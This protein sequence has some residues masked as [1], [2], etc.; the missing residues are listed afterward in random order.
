MRALAWWKLPTCAALA[1]A[2]GCETTTPCDTPPTIRPNDSPFIIC[3]DAS[4]EDGF[5]VP[6][7]LENRGCEDLKIERAEVRFDP[8]G[9]FT[10]PEIAVGS[11][12]IVPD[13][14]GFVRLRYKPEVAGEDHVWLVIVSNDPA[15]PELRLP[16]CGPGMRRT[17]PTAATECTE[18]SQCGEGLR[19]LGDGPG[20]SVAVCGEDGD[21][22]GCTCR[23]AVCDMVRNCCCPPDAVSAG[24]CDPSGDPDFC[25]LGS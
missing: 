19:C 3:G 15:N 5:E 17:D 9:S 24:E 21:S 13:G 23:P 18:S 2:L 6:I 16:L 11:D 14:E 1:L 25:S 7:L 20:G 8:K 10:A 22:D 12:T 4:G